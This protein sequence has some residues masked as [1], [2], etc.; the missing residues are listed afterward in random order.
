VTSSPM[1]TC[2]R[3]RR[4]R[5]P[6]ARAGGT[7]PLSANSGDCVSPSHRRLATNASCGGGPAS[8]GHIGATTAMSSMRTTSGPDGAASG[9][10]AVAASIVPPGTRSRQAA[11]T[12]RK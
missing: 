7:A 4:T 9:A 3:A 11:S 12:R 8:F 2:S 1:V 5:T 6:A 10:D